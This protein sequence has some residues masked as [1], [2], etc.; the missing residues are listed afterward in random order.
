MELPLRVSHL[1]E[2]A[3][4]WI[5]K[6]ENNALTTDIWTNYIEKKHKTKMQQNID[7][8]ENKL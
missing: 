4:I 6:Q 8:W 2:I 5:P 1:F 3:H 7:Q